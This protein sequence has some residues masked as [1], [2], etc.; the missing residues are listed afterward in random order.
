MYASIYIK[1]ERA[2]P[3]TRERKDKGNKDTREKESILSF[4]PPPFERL[5]FSLLHLSV[6]LTDS[7]F[8]PP[9]P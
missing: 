6:Q 3:K 8:P 2:A 7:P 5:P 4:F 9:A 1:R